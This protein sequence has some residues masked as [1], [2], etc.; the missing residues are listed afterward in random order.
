[1]QTPSPAAE[2]ISQYYLQPLQQPSV[3]TTGPVYAERSFYEEIPSD[4]D[5]RTNEM[6]YQRLNVAPGPAPAVFKP[7]QN[8]RI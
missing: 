7:Y 4:V 6:S 1:M 2:N 3:Y 5:N 8:L